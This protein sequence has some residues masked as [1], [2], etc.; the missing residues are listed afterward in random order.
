VTFLLLSNKFRSP[1]T[2]CIV[3]LSVGKLQLTR[4]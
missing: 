3:S 2:P 1:T 4:T